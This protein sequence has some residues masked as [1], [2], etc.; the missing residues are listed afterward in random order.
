MKSTARRFAEN[1]TIE[2]TATPFDRDLAATKDFVTI[3]AT[4]PSIP[5]VG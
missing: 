2:V 5:T 4:R 3:E 1:P